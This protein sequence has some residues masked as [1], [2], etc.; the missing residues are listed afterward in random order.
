MTVLSKSQF[1]G[2]ITPRSHDRWGIL[3]YKIYRNGH[4]KLFTILERTKW[5]LK[6]EYHFE[7]T[8]QY[9]FIYFFYSTS[10]FVKQRTIK[11]IFL[12]ILRNILS[13]THKVAIL[14]SMATYLKENKNILFSHRI[15]GKLALAEIDFGTIAMLLIYA[16]NHEIPL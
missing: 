9:N 15:D 11:T 10:P 6:G 3:Y 1:R 7:N 16:R 5:K 8:T 4:F 13:T 12:F 14:S 2:L